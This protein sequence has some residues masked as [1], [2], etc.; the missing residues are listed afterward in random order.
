MWRRSPLAR[1]NPRN[2]GWMTVF[3]QW[4]KDDV[5]HYGVWPR[6]KHSYNP[7]FQDFVRR[8]HGEDIDDVPL[9]N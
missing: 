4:V 1:A 9:Q 2:R 7:V 3:K 6:V 8:F 5:F